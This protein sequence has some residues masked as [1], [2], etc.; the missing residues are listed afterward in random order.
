M[1][2]FGL[3]V[4]V[5]FCRRVSS[6]TIRHHHAIW[7]FYARPT[8]VSRPQNVLLF[9]SRKKDLPYL[10][11]RRFSVVFNQIFFS[12][13]DSKLSVGWVLTCGLKLTEFFPFSIQKCRFCQALAQM[14]NF[15]NFSVV[16]PYF[17]KESW[18]FENRVKNH[19]HSCF[20]KIWGKKIQLQKFWNFCAFNPHI[21]LVTRLFFI[22]NQNFA[23]NL[24]FK[25]PLKKTSLIIC[26][27]GF[28]KIYPRYAEDCNACFWIL[29]ISLKKAFWATEFE[30]KCFQ[31]IWNP[32]QV[33]HSCHNQ[34]S[35]NF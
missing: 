5:I 23:K 35:R 20:Q 29:K 15:S 30:K 18:V 1:I 22:F 13:D 12:S 17:S 34:F 10:I 19:S 4:N 27:F 16:L 7:D 21:D 33:S 8:Y 26:E 2:G 3:G 25:E 32:H 28:L 9:K 6:F 24:D 31:L 14:V 11:S